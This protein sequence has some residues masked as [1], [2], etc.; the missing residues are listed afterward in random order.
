[1]LTD[2]SRVAELIIEFGVAVATDA[3]YTFKRT[4]F[5]R[6]KA[7]RAKLIAHATRAKRERIFINFLRGL[8]EPG[9]Y[10]PLAEGAVLPVGVDAGIMFQVSIR[11]FH[12]SPSRT[13]IVDQ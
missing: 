9:C 3:T 12:A 1:V 10:W 5:C 4:D 13:Q 8:K 2:G 11:N 6:A 7:D